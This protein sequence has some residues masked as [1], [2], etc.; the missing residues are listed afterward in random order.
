VI[1]DLLADAPDFDPSTG[2]RD[3]VTALEAATRDE[4]DED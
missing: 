4:S 2:E 1:A 3:W